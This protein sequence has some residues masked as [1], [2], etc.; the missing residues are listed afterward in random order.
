ML[1]I[2]KPELSLEYFILSVVKPTRPLALVGLGFGGRD[3][4][5]QLRVSKLEAMNMQEAPRQMGY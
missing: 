2:L 3:Q 4:T 5:L 1:K